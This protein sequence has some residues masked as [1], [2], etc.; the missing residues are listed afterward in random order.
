MDVAVAEDPL[1]AMRV[2]ELRAFGDELSAALENE[3]ELDAETAEVSAFSGDSRAQGAASE[4]HAAARVEPRGRVLRFPVVAWVAAGIAAAAGIAVV[5]FAGRGERPLGP[6]EAGEVATAGSPI[7]EIAAAPGPARPFTP[8]SEPGPVPAVSTPEE[9]RVVKNNTEQFPSKDLAPIVPAEMRVATDPALEGGMAVATAP[10]TPSSS[11]AVSAGGTPAP[12]AILEEPKLPTVPVVVAAA[13]SSEE[14]QGGDVRAMLSRARSQ[15]ASGDIAAAAATFE[16]VRKLDSRN[17]EATY[18]SARIAQ[19]QARAVGG[20]RAV[21]NGRRYP[22]EG[23]FV[24]ATGVGPRP[25]V[26]SPTLRTGR[27]VGPRTPLVESHF[28]PARS[29][30][31]ST[32]AADVDTASYSSIRRILRTS[33]SRLMLP[34]EMSRQDVRIE[35]LINYFPYRYTPPS[36]SEGIDS[37]EA[38]AAHLAVASAPWNP[39]HRL[40]RVALKAIEAVPEER[41]EANLVFVIDLS[42][43]MGV[44]GGLDLVKPALLQLV[45]RL[46]PEDR[47]AIVGFGR[48]AKVLLSSTRVERLSAIKSVIQGMRL[49]GATNGEAGI[50]FG[51][52]IAQEH[53]SAEKVN[54]VI[55]CTDGGFNVGATQE[56]QLLRLIREKARSRVFLT[57]LGFGMSMRGSD[58][59]LEKLANNGNGVFGFVDSVSEARKLLVDEIDGT[60]ATV[61]KDVKIQVEFN[62]ALVSSYRLIGY[63]NRAL[64]KDGF[65]D[66]AVDAG[67]VGFGHAVTAL[68]EIDPA[69]GGVRKRV[70]ASAEEKAAAERLLTLRIRYKSPRDEEARAQEFSLADAGRD[71][72]DADEDFRFAAAVAAWGMLIRESSYAGGANIDAV[73]EWAEE[74]LGYDPGGYRR[75][76]L[77]LVKESRWLTNPNNNPR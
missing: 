1:L 36:A 71:F 48:E 37:Q 44:G 67:E 69:R 41:P 14:S 21:W 11:P 8:T 5:F 42:G 53:F 62:P 50:E 33:R 66:A 38:F 23:R 65:E 55:F 70:F 28:V 2:A 19:E 59:R 34:H 47:V 6:R 15:Y 51:Y 10:E 24:A 27:S 56:T 26:P 7:E 60:L 29:N 68:Y 25:S 52:Q 3:P 54:R 22:S 64:E 32:F 58:E 46:R 30:P 45:D 4:A 72:E 73:R 43:S 18:F 31:V 74:C 9:P 61:A 16:A 39:D 12:V 76:F 35:E 20:R 17:R 13:A 77:E 57:V 75:E 63:E 49:G 40:V